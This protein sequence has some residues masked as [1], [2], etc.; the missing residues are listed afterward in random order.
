LA[1]IYDVSTARATVGD[2]LRDI[3][4]SIEGLITQLVALFPV[5]FPGLLLLWFNLISL[6][7]KG[8][9]L[10]VDPGGSISVRSGRAWNRLWSTG[11]GGY[12]RRHGYR[13]HSAVRWSACHPVAAEPDVRT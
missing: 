2:V 5:L 4:V 9:E 3:V 12:R 6:F 11:I 10:E 1:A 8:S 7:T 13:L